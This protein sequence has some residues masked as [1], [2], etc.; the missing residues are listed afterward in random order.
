MYCD[1]IFKGACIMILII[2]LLITID[3]LKLLPKFMVRPT[4]YMFRFTGILLIIGFICYL[5]NS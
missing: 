5:L 4:I 1:Y 3:Y 2:I